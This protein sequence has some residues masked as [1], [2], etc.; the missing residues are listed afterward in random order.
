MNERPWLLPVMVV[1]FIIGFIGAIML[2]VW[3]I[4]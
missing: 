3:L 4:T 2:H 1:A